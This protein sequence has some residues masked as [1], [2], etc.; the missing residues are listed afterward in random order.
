MAGCSGAVSMQ[1]WAQLR[2][3]VA[4]GGEAAREKKLGNLRTQM[5]DLLKIGKCQITEKKQVLSW[6]SGSL[7]GVMA[8]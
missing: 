6:V 3:K 2:H 7:E 4:F 8:K 5:E 1:P